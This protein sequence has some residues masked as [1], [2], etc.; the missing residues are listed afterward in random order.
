M[1]NG[2]RHSRSPRELLPELWEA[3]GKIVGPGNR[4]VLDC[5]DVLDSFLHFG[6]TSFSLPLARAKAVQT[7]GILARGDSCELSFGGQLVQPV[8]DLSQLSQDGVPGFPNLMLA[9]LEKR[10]GPL[11]SSGF[12]SLM[13]HRLVTPR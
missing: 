1:S 13:S 7:V 4:I 12:C 8:A 10:L 5:R 3:A 11:L 2:Q 6:E 9:L